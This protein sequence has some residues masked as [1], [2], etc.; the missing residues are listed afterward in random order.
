[1][2]WSNLSEET[3]SIINSYANIA[4]IIGAALVLVGT[5]TIFWTG[6]IKEIYTN[7]LISNNKTKAE[8]A[9]K[10]AE[11]AKEHTA[12]LF[13]E[14]EQ[15]RLEQQRLKA[16]L[17]WRRLN[18]EQIIILKNNLNNQINDKIWLTFVG[19]DPE[20]RL[21]YEDFNNVFSSLNIPTKFFN[22]YTMAVGLRILGA[23]S[24]SKS[25][26]IDAFKKAG[27]PF[28]IAIESKFNYDKGVEIL[29]GSK[30]PV[31]Q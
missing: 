19:D 23:D 27:I 15:A 18:K 8:V 30:P 22:G 29:V 14:A 12:K 17:A 9:Q 10:E 7:E 26:V 20:S 16:Q 3:A 25:V 2:G 6:G 11:K 21:Y 31:F 24:E 5:I 28:D 1:M 4:V 13:L